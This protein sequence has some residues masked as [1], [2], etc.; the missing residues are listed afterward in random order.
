VVTSSARG[1][2][3]TFYGGLPGTGEHHIRVRYMFVPTLDVLFLR[4][5]GFAEGRVSCELE[6]HQNAFHVFR[7]GNCGSVS[8]RK[9]AVSFTFPCVRA[10]TLGN[11]RAQVALNL[12]TKE[13]LHAGS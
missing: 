3:D 5:G 6:E 12:A 1:G 11:S 7:G 2:R 9:R 8:S 4:L 10:T 13:P